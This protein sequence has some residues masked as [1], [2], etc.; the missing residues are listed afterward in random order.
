MRTAGRAHIDKAVEA[1]NP[2]TRCVVQVI[3][4]ADDSGSRVAAVRLELQRIASA[5]SKG[6]PGKAAQVFILTRNRK[7]T[8]L[9]E[10][11]NAEVIGSMARQFK[12]KG[13]EVIHSSLHSSKGLSADYVG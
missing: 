1:V 6:R 2:A 13:L 7:D 12:G 10:G 3:E 11:L 5:Q 8:K 4:H 9:P